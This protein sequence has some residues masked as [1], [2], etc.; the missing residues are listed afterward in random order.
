MGCD[1]VKLKCYNGFDVHIGK[2]KRF[3]INLGEDVTGRTFHWNI[4]NNVSDAGFAYQ[5]TNQPNQ[6]TSGIY[7]SDLESGLLEWTLLDTDSAGA[8]AGEK[9]FEFYFVQGGHQELLF[10]G[11]M[12]FSA[13]IFG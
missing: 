10:E 1:L 4:K 3:S 13:G 7:V 9:P 2:V 8:S 6:T 11:Y 5:L 12:T